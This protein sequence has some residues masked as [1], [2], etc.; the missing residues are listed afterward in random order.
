MISIVYCIFDL[1]S[2]TRGFILHRLHSWPSGLLAVA[3]GRLRSRSRDDSRRTHG[4]RPA[5]PLHRVARNDALP[6][7]ANVQ[8][9][10]RSLPQRPRTARGTA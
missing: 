1:I 4:R 10:R 9:R 6:H 3:A 2:L 7:V 5:G 8:R